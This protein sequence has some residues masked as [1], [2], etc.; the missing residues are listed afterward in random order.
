MNLVIN[1]HEFSGERVLAGAMDGAAASL[2]LIGRLE[3]QHQTTLLFLDFSGIDVAT[4]S[5][6]REFLFPV[7]DWCRGNKTNLYPVIANA[8]AKIRDELVILLGALNEALVICDYSDGSHSNPRILGQLEEKQRETL[9]ILN[10]VRIS[11]AP[12][13]ARD[14]K[15]HAAN[16]T[17]WNNRLSALAAKGILIASESGRIKRYQC[18]LEGLNCGQ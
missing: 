6:L 18:V 16:P 3:R 2:K 17:A 7:R 8:S 5:F 15:Q 1:L 4:A 12:T 13:L 9:K 10:K 14:F 11:D